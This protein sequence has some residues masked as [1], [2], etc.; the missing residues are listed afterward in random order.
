MFVHTVFAAH[1]YTAI[2]LNF[3]GALEIG[4]III[5]LLQTRQLTLGCW[6]FVL[7][8]IVSGRFLNLQPLKVQVLLLR[9]MGIITDF[10]P[11]FVED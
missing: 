11:W 8:L 9:P 5:S 1:V 7:S 10:E 6:E 3:T 4:V 2:G